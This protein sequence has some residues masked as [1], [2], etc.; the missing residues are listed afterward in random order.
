[1]ETSFLA[2]SFLRF[3]WSAKLL[4]RIGGSDG[5]EAAQDLGEGVLFRARL[6]QIINLKHE[7]VQLADKIDWSWIDQRAAM[8]AGRCA[9]AKQI[10]S[11]RKQLRL[12]RARLGR[13][14]RDIRRK[15]EGNRESETAFE[16]ALARASHI[17]SQRQGGHKL[18]SF[19]APET[20]CIGK[21][22]APNES[23]VNNLPSH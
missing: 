9:H 22:S 12:R 11:Y 5:T 16:I 1:M 18:Y 19:H 21:A 6:E 8:M 2:V 15:I 23:A 14:I 10:N 13:I 3:P 17:R 4:V 20:E 7:L